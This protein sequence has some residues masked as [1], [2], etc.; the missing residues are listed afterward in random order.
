MQNP[1]DHLRWVETERIK[2]NSYNPN[3]Q[4][5]E[6]LALL[7]ESIK[8]NGWTQPI[9]VRPIKSGVHVIVDGEH[10]YMAARALKQSKVPVVI[11]EASDKECIAATVRHNRARGVHGLDGMLHIV[12]QLRSE[13]V[14]S[15]Q[16]EQMLG[17]T[18]TERERLEA[19]E[20][21]FLAVQ[22]GQDIGM[23]V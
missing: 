1:I 11:L 8:A 6:S 21:A 3:S 17:M 2:P 23:A 15:A 10:R 18:S 16:I 7:T 19:S 13:G 4:L 9:V 12:K 22:A 14:E 5:E 20:E